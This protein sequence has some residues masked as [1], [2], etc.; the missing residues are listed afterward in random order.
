[1]YFI[2]Y[3][4]PSSKNSKV[5]TSKGVFHSESVRKYLQKIGVKKYGRDGVEEYAKRPN[6]FRQSF[7]GFTWSEYPAV[8]MFHFVRDSRRKFDFHNAV[9]IIA[10]LMVAHGLIPDDNMDYFLPVPMEIN[11]E[12]YTVDKEKAGVYVDVVDKETYFRRLIWEQKNRK[13]KEK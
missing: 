5:A 2:P 6:L 3:N 4:V 10:D 13:E 11:G 9:Q 7:T 12:C 1:M 8:F